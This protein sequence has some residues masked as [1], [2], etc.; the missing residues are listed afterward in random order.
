[1]PGSINSASSYSSSRSSAL[2]RHRLTESRARLETLGHLVGLDMTA[3]S[4]PPRPDSPMSTMQDDLRN[5]YGAPSIESTSAVVAQVAGPYVLGPD[6]AP[7]ESETGRPLGRKLSLSGLSQRSRMSDVS[8]ARSRSRGHNRSRARNVTLSE[9]YAR[10]HGYAHSSASDR[11]GSEYSIMRKPVPREDFLRPSV[12]QH[13][14]IL[15]A[16]PGH[17]KTASESGY[18]R[19]RSHSNIGVEG[20][21]TREGR[22]DMDQ[23]LQIATS[24]MPEWA[25]PVLSSTPFDISQPLVARSSP[26]SVVQ[27][28]DEDNMG[29]EDIDVRRGSTAT[30]TPETYAAG[31]RT[32]RSR[33]RTREDINAQQYVSAGRITNKLS[34]RS[35][36]SRAT[37]EDNHSAYSAHSAHSARSARSARS[38]GTTSYTSHGTGFPRLNGYRQQVPPSVAASSQVQWQMAEQA[39]S[40]RKPQP[41]R[42]QWTAH[43][44]HDF[45]GRGQ[46][47]PFERQDIPPPPPKSPQQPYQREQLREQLR[48]PSLFI[49]PSQQPAKSFTVLA[50][51]RTTTPPSPASSYRGVSPTYSTTTGSTPGVSPTSYRSSQVGD[52][53]LVSPLTPTTPAPTSTT[54]RPRSQSSGSRS[55]SPSPARG[56]YNPSTAEANRGGGGV[57]ARVEDAMQKFK[58]RSYH[59]R[60]AAGLEAPAGFAVRE[61]ARRVPQEDIASW[62]CPTLKAPLGAVP[63]AQSRGPSFA[64]RMAAAGGDG[65]MAALGRRGDTQGMS[66]ASESASSSSSGMHHDR[67]VPVARGYGPPAKTT[68][69]SPTRPSGAYTGRGSTRS[70]QEAAELFVQGTTPKRQSFLPPLP[71]SQPVRGPPQPRHYVPAHTSPACDFN[72]SLDEDRHIPPRPHPTRERPKQFEC[73]FDSGHSSGVRLENAAASKAATPQRRIETPPSFAAVLHMQRSD[74]LFMA[75][76]SMSGGSNTNRMMASTRMAFFSPWTK[77]G[78]AASTSTTLAEHSAYSCEQSDRAPKIEHPGPPQPRDDRRNLPSQIQRQLQRRGDRV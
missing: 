17:Q 44:Y 48:P 64:Q 21:M 3:L 47:A 1:M 49:P 61:S 26:I 73:G 30:I 19:G 16:G 32:P 31:C 29:V 69:L 9:Q 8:S 57:R 15:Y 20:T 68:P 28:M 71:P 67:P 62:Q 54:R 39:E 72:S 40:R 34:R 27:S 78:Q 6:A 12:S 60:Q 2:E 74:S 18:I 33:S 14:S 7:G 22:M 43:S 75:G 36:R 59:A 24:A 63:A 50:T 58:R 5:L 53:S 46:T 11:S 45:G 55:R 56:A 77:N 23:E 37:D 13:P 70:E 52:S 4:P 66:S 35:S 38:A 25:K 51:K 65:G 10:S 42:Q 41:R 76:G